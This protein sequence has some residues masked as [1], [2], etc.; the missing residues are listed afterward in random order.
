LDVSEEPLRD[1]KKGLLWP[2]VEP[3]QR[4]AGDERG[5]LPATDAQGVSHWRHA[6]DD[7]EVVSHSLNEGLVDSIF[8]L[9]ALE[10]LVHLR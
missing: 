9:W 2:G 7:V 4:A 3:V 10:A 1:G 8:G 5:E 6:Q